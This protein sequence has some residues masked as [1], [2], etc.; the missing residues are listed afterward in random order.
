VVVL[1]ECISELRQGGAGSG[2]ECG[3]RDNSVAGTVARQFR[4]PA[5]EGLRLTNSETLKTGSY[6]QP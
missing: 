5:G 6:R 2:G 3:L 4:L 1:R